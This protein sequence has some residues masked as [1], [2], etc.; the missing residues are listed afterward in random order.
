MATR[1]SRLIRVACD[2]SAARDTARVAASRAAPAA[3]A[4]A[5]RPEAAVATSS[6]AARS[7]SPR[8][9][10]VGRGRGYP[11]PGLD[12]TDKDLESDEAI[13]TMYENWCKVYNMERDHEEMTRRPV[14]S[15]QGSCKYS[16]RNVRAFR[17]WC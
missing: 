17:L 6:R 7:G 2:A 9:R 10:R 15:I 5:S 16:A 4:A 3:A 14:P 8:S 1:V 13:W 11:V 12:V